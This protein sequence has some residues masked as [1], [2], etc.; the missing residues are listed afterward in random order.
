MTLEV[1]GDILTSLWLNSM[2]KKQYY[3]YN[4]TQHWPKISSADW[5]SANARRVSNYLHALFLGLFSTSILSRWLAFF[6][7][8]PQYLFWYLDPNILR[9]NEVG[10]KS[11]LISNYRAIASGFWNRFLGH[12]VKFRNI[13][14]KCLTWFTSE[15]S[16]NSDCLNW[17]LT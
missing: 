6:R 2:S 12:L 17:D 4:K 8:Y 15:L 13:C 9:I 10:E 1:E 5:P 11:L 16:L 7:L 3:A 14:I